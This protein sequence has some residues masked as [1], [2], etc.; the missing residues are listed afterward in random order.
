MRFPVSR[1]FL[2]LLPVFAAIALPVSPAFAGEDDGTGGGGGGGNSATLHASQGCVSGPRTNA[3]VT[4]NNIAKVT[5]YVDGKRVKTVTQP[6]AQGRFAFSMK[7]SRLSL[8]A[9]R[10]SAVVSFAQGSSPAR[11]TL[12]FQITRAAQVSPRYT[13]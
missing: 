9:H 2:L 8:G 10:A 5:F 7:C 11:Q 12:R 13:G 4:G 3:A 6:N 1:R